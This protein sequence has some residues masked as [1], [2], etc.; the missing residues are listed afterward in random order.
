ML[1]LVPRVAACG[2]RQAPGWQ[3]GVAKA[4][5]LVAH[6]CAVAFTRKAVASGS[7][8]PKLPWDEKSLR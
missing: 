3:Q 2:I 5:T 1:P 6:A 8:R 4:V 7:Q